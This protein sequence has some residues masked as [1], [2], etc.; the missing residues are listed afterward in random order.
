MIASILVFASIGF[1]QAAERR[2]PRLSGTLTESTYPEFETFV[3]DHVNKVAGLKITVE[4]ARSDDAP[5]QASA[6]NGPL[7]IYL[8]STPDEPGD[9][10]IVADNGFSYRDG[11][12]R[13]DGL[14]T[15]KNKGTHQ[16]VVS[17]SLRKA[18]ASAGK[19]D[20]AIRFEPVELGKAQ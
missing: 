15:I 11:A 6:D 4:R 12:Y 5:L 19:I 8:K 13:L 16:G 1:A 14:F 17:Y 7:V 9:S 20:P 3:D 2:I 18:A 10:E